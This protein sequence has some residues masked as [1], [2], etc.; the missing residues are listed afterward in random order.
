MN[1]EVLFAAASALQRAA[2]DVVA[3]H[4]HIQ[5]ESALLESAGDADALTVVREHFLLLAAALAQR[6]QQLRSVAL[7]LI[8]AGA[9]ADL[10]A[11]AVA[12][13]QPYA[14]SSPAVARVVGQLSAMGTAL[15]VMCARQI[16]L[17]CTPIFPAPDLQLAHYP[18]LSP[19]QMHEINLPT[20]PEEIQRLARENPDLRVL[21][22]PEGGL[23]AAVGDL[24][25]AETV[26]TYVAGV[27]SSDPA[28]WSTQLERTRGLSA[29]T[30]GAHGAGVLWLGYRAPESLAHG[31]Q[32][33]PAESAGRNLAA[34]Q[35][36]LARRYP[37]QQRVVVGYSYGAV[38]VGQAARRGLHADDAVLVAAPGAGVG[39]VRDMV[40]FG[41]SPR[42]H[43]FM[44]PGDPIGLLTGPDGGLHGT[45]PGAPGFGARIGDPRV[46]R[47]HSSYFRDPGFLDAVGEAV[48]GR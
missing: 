39:S 18:E 25:R 28:G 23:V 4:T 43:A 12:T 44:S 15:D 47:G 20:A 34:F 3:E 29:A 31:L 30:S 46:N 21:E 45:E 16:R 7:T 24:E 33:A 10:L 32:K 22:L 13:A 36:E 1:A 41:D 17:L 42:V 26:V 37:D 27:G 6:E 11:R 5:Q 19:E 40:L 48:R 9:L 38:V 8:Q 14:D 35:A 2:D